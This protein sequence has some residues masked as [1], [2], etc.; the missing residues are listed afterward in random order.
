MLGH[1]MEPSQSTLESRQARLAEQQLLLA[2]QAR[3]LLL[4]QLDGGL[5]GGQV[6]SQRRPQRRLHALQLLCS[7]AAMSSKDVDEGRTEQ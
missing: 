4:V 6:A 1:C 3:D 5:E 7:P 2:L